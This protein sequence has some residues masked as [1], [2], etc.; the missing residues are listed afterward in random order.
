MKGACAWDLRRC[1]SWSA[2]SRE[3]SSSPPP[4]IE[5][6]ESIMDCGIGGME[7]AVDEEG[8]MVGAKLSRSV[9]SSA[10]DSYSLPNQ[11]FQRKSDALAKAEYGRVSLAL[12]ALLEDLLS[13]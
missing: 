5:N 1:I 6:R 12:G 10:I 7:P 9:S 4:S 11:N 8:E 2:A 3:K 13:P